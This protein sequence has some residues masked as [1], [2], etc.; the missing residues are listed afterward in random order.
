MGLARI[1]QAPASGDGRREGSHVEGFTRGAVSRKENRV[2]GMRESKK[3]RY[4]K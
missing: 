1:G 2:T 3:K 4:V